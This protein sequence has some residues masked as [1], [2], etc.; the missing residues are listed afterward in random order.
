M[1]L[2]VTAATGQLGGAI[3]KE[4]IQKLGKQNVIG[5]SRDPERA[6]HLGIEVR[7]GDYDDKE[8]YVQ[9][10][11]GIEAVLLVSGLDA[12]ARRI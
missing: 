5:I 7:P 3:I 9:A 12:P 8:T 11:T 6:D 2:G 4:A 1:K 10:L